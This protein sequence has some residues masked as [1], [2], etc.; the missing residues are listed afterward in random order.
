MPAGRVKGLNT[1]SD[2]IVNGEQKM[3]ANKKIKGVKRQY[4]RI[5]KRGNREGVVLAS[6][7]T[8][9][10]ATKT[11]IRLREQRSPFV[12]NRITVSKGR[13]GNKK[14]RSYIVMKWSPKE[15]I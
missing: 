11:A 6:S 8:R 7:P 9:S 15:S 1:P 12:R 10:G 5:Y 14:R 2:T 3:V 13:M 4:L